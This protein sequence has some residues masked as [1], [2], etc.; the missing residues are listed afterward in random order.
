VLLL[1]V[2]LLCKRHGE[3][4]VW[5]RQAA[6]SRQPQPG[7]LVT[8]ALRQLQQIQLCTTAGEQQT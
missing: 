3:Q 5:D 4:D 2:L 6:R 8:A 7:A 1:T